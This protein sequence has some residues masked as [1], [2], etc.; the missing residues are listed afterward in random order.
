[1]QGQHVS[2][3]VKTSSLAKPY[4]ISICNVGIYGT[5]YVRDQALPS[6][7]IVRLTETYTLKIDHIY[8]RLTIGNTLNI[9]LRL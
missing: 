7:V 1:M 3:E 2:V 6:N 8:S 9:K 4:E 5:F